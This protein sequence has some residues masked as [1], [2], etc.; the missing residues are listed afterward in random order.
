MKNHGIYEFGPFQISISERVLRREDQIVPLTPKCFDTL[1]ILAEHRGSVVAKEKLMRAVWPDSFV[2]EANLAQNICTLRKTLGTAAEGER[3]IQTI[4]KRGYRL[5]VPV[6]EDGPAAN[7]QDTAVCEP[8]PRRSPLRT[9]LWRSL[10]IAAVLVAACVAGLTLRL[11][12]SS[13]SSSVPQIAL[14]TVPNDLIY[15]VISPDGKQIAYVSSD[16]EGQSLWIR[17]TGGVGA[18]TR[19]LPPAAGHF[20]GMSYSPD[21]QYL[22]RIF[23]DETHPAEGILSRISLKSRASEE[24]LTGI[25]A[26][27]AFSPDGKRMVFK[28]YDLRG[29]GY[30]IT[31]TPSGR[32][33]KVIAEKDASYPFYNYQWAADGRGIYYVERANDSNSG[34]W[35]VWEI[36]AS[37][38]T[39]ELVM[40]PQPKPL[41]SVTWLNGS[42]MLALIP[43]ADTGLNQ[44][45]RVSAGGAFRPLT[46]GI[47]NYTFIS[48]TADGRALLANS[49]ETHDSIWTASVSGKARTEPTRVPLPAGTYDDPAWTPDGRI[50]FAGQA[51]LWLSSADGRE[52]RPLIPDKTIATEPSVSGDGRFLVFV[53]QRGNSRNLWRIDLNGGNLRQVTGGPFDWHPAVSPDSRWV[54]YESRSP[55]HW[56]LCKAPLSEFGPPVRLVEDEGAEAGIAIDS[57]SKL[58]AYRNDLGAVAIRAIEDGRLVQTLAARCD[59]A[60]LHW[61]AGGSAITYVCHKGRVVQLWRQPVAGGPPVPIPAP[62]PEDA[63]RIGWSRDGSRLIYLHREIRGDLA[64]LSNLR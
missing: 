38:G 27:P 60:D 50:V 36:P 2:E 45:W 12:P 59:P 39:A 34:A 8:A 48:L 18:G 55:G 15:A 31:A 6:S 7:V 44:I 41:R 33:R 13:G 63:Q 4:P 5:A 16:A 30:L 21:G 42:E 43:N 52:R 62:L 29:H 3:Y 46:N 32:D 49:M 11:W 56:T 24:L 9:P 40:A 23:E 26:A 14:L 25:S 1:L 64:L 57:E 22:Y 37:G 61:S 53:S 58:F 35:S 20:W 54:L 51:N 28:R 47:N 17:E 10:P 19:L